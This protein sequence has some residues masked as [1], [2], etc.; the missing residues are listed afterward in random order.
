MFSVTRVNGLLPSLK[1]VS[2]ACVVIHTSEH[3][4][5]LKNKKI[6]SQLFNYLKQTL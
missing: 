2:I 3:T 4:K 6:K 1:Q 5:V